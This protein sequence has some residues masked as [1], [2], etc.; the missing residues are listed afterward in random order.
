MYKDADDTNLLEKYT[1]R[2]LNELVRMIVPKG[3]LNFTKN[4][5]VIGKKVEI[6]ALLTKNKPIFHAKHDLDTY[7]HDLEKL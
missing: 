7:I 5:H 4:N 3:E 6:I 2:E 1:I